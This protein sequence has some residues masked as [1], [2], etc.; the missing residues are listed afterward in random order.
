MGWSASFQ[1]AFLVIAT[2][3][4]DVDRHRHHQHQHQKANEK[5]E[6]NGVLIEAEPQRFQELKQLHEPLGNTCICAEVSCQPF[7]SRSLSSILKRDAP[8]LSNE[9]DFLSIDVDG[10]DYWIM[11]DLLGLPIDN[12]GS[13]NNNNNNSNN[14]ED[15]GNT[16]TSTING[17]RPKVIC[18]EFNPT[19]PMDLIYIQPRDGSVRH[20]SSLS[21][22]VEL[23]TAADYTL[24]ETTL[25]NAF[26]VQNE[27]Y[28]Q[29]L[30][31]EVPDTSIE[32]LHEI[33]MGTE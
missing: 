19:M 3:D 31:K 1:H 16:N 26:F 28:E 21:A 18:I 13:N 7:S 23:A 8:Y 10:M 33:T 25:F 17:Y 9:F 5:V 27:L 14:N 12:E 29:Y 32:A 30:T 4:Q 15:G 22:M 2:G 6:W 24:A 11:A 20:G